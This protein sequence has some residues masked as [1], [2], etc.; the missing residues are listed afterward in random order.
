VRKS[1]VAAL[2]V[3]VLAGAAVAA[4]PLVERHA[5]EQIKADIERDGATKLGSVEVGLFDRRIVLNDLR[6]KRFGE[7][8]I[9][10]WEASGLAWPFEELVRGRTPFAGLQLGDPVHAGRLELRDLRM[11]DDHTRWSIASV[12]IDDF[13][14][15]RYDPLIRPNQ[16][17]HVIARIGAHLTMGRLEQKDVMFT[18][19]ASGDQ[20]RIPSLS[21]GRYDKGLIGS[22]AIAGFEFTRKPPR[23]PLFRMADFKLTDLDLRR[24]LQTTGAPTWRPG[25]PIGRF[26]L[27]SANLSGFG[28]EGFARYGL[29]LGSITQQSQVQSNGVRHSRLRIDGF[30]L[31]P[32][33]RNREALQL[34]VVLQAMGLKEL[35][36]DSDCSG[37][38]DR[39]KGEVSVDRCAVVGP[40]LGEVTLSLKLVQADAAFWKAIDESNTFALLGSKAGLGGVKL[41]IAD[42]GLVERSLKAVAATTGQTLPQVRADFAQ[43]I[44]RFQPPGILISEDLTKLL[45]T[46]ARFIERGGTLTVEAKPEVPI[47]LDKIEYFSRPGPDLVNVLGLSATLSR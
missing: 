31:D 44:R 19:S 2:A 14:L 35:K 45:D 22:L 42:R 8:T 16:F 47:G 6:A 46:V 23:D 27:G 18:D 1:L 5:A 11:A 9:G 4:V 39:A 38:E 12:V 17:S 28:G 24:T 10:R 36:L 20:M 7:I 26:D 3:V 37:T 29:S 25:M 32:P 13:H 34:R 15:D 40:D 33:L 21:V 43:E 30:V 41:V